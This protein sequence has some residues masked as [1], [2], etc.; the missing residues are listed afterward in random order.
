MDLD[1]FL[2]SVIQKGT[3]DIHFKVGSPPI[4]RIDGNLLITK[5]PS[6]NPRDTASL[7]FTFLN[8]SA[9][10][11]FRSLTEIDTTYTIQDKARFR[12]NIYRQQGNFSIAMRYIPYYIPTMEHLGIPPLA[13]SF[14]LE[15]R[16]L[17]LVT[18]PTGSGKTTTL[19]SMIDYIN[20]SIKAHI[21]TI[22]DPIEFVHSD[23]KSVIN[24]REVGVDTPSFLVALKSAMR[25]DPDVLLIGEMRDSET[26]ATA[27]RAVS[28][29]HLVFSSFH[30]TNAVETISALINYFP[31]HQQP[32]IRSQLA[33]NLVGVISQRLLKLKKGVGRA[34]AAE[35]MTV[36]STIQSCILESDKI[37]QIHRFIAQGKTEYNMQTFDQAIMKIFKDGLITKDEALLNC[38]SPADFKRALNFGE[39]L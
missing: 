4:L 24:Q 32:Q 26:I 27:L 7:T 14:C 15:K 35:A 31:P 18:G 2:L 6:L 21:I 10:R 16:G 13:K 12:V 37:N 20:K 22:E 8:R 23:I 34:L 38:S 25:E 39:E 5:G 30:T 3:S 29:G 1:S 17:I 28:T 36:T 19:A 33:S 9:M 11:N